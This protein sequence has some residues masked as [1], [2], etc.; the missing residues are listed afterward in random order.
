MELG[1]LAFGNSRGKYPLDRNEYE[2]IVIRGLSDI[3]CDCYGVLED[4]ELEAYRNE[5]GGI[6]TPVF[7]ICSYWWGDEDDLEAE[8]PNFKHIPTGFTIDWYKY[9]LRESYA[10]Q[11]LDPDRVAEIFCECTK[12]ARELK[13]EKTSGDNW[14][15][16]NEKLG[17]S[18]TAWADGPEAGAWKGGNF[19]KSLD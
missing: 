2:D 7:E 14:R 3:G 16:E 4:K 12:F 13:G 8:R 10:N 18:P 5:R 19:M 11:D 6:T 15:I 1:N 17:Q 9:A